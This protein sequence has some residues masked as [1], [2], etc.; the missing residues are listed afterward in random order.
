MKIPV[1]INNKNLI[2]W[3]KKM[4]EDLKSFDNI[5]DIIIV[6]NESS[7]EPLLEWYSTNP[8]EIIYSKN[9]GQSSPWNNMIP[10]KRSFEYYVV[11]DS[12]LDLS[13]TPK[14]CLNVL[15]EKI[16]SHKEY[17]RIGLSLCNYDVSVNSPYHY[18]LKTWAYHN[19]NDDDVFDGLLTKQIID[20]TFGMYHIERNR[21]G[22]SCSTN[23]P[24]SA[25]HIPWEITWD[26]ILDLK[27]K[28]YEFYYYL[29]NATGASSYRNFINFD[30]INYE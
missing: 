21:S 24:Y 28:N 5:G 2:T 12:D 23:F 26:E 6:D 30:G 9:F 15:L 18:H 10:E 22:S 3:P 17:D 1:I 19:W 20:T 13:E 27:N 4:V 25:K 11:T 16:M 8:C 14:D 7:Y 29:K